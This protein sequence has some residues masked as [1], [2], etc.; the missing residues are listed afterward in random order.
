MNDRLNHHIA[1]LEGVKTRLQNA[2]KQVDGLV[3]DE[4]LH[5]LSQV[6]DQLTEHSGSA[7]EAG[8]DWLAA[9]FTHHPQLAPAVNRDLLWFFGGECL[10]FLTDDEIDRFQQLDE[11]EADA[12]ANGE[13][14]DRALTLQTLSTGNQE[15]S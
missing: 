15:P 7:Y 11:L 2:N 9:L 13:D 5:Q 6:I 3:S 8:Q 1:M 10:H 4:I 12:V 14:F